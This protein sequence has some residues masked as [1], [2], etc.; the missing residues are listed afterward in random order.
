MCPNLFPWL[1]GFWGSLPVKSTDQSGKPGRHWPKCL[2]RRHSGFSLQMKRDTLGMFLM[3]SLSLGVLTSTKSYCSKDVPAP[4]GQAPP[5]RPSRTHFLYSYKHFTDSLKVAFSPKNP[6]G[7]LLSFST[8]F[9]D[10]AGN[11]LGMVTCPGFLSHSSYLFSPLPVQSSPNPVSSS[12][13]P[14][15]L[16]R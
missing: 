10:W 5:G 15:L 7:P 6:L 8:L 3:V 14:W 4:C 13:G 1:R 16:A 11:T 2:F 9:S 12:R